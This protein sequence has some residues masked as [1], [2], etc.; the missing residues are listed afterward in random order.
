VV[1]N[2]ANNAITSQETGNRETNSRESN[3]QD[4]C[5][6]RKHPTSSRVNISPANRGSRKKL[7]GK[8]QGDKN[9]VDKRAG[10]MADALASR[11]LPRLQC[12]WRQSSLL[13][14][15]SSPHR[16]VCRL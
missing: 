4:S 11:G 9:Q 6:R 3:S 12:R 10:M 5:S 15:P 1:F 16:F 8:N 2:R 14:Q 13:C 7:A